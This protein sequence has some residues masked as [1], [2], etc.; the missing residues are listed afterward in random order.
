MSPALASVFVA[1]NFLMKALMP[2]GA[3]LLYV[4]ICSVVRGM[5]QKQRPDEGLG[6]AAVSDKR[7]AYLRLPCSFASEIFFMRSKA[8]TL[9]HPGNR[10]TF[11]GG[12]L[13]LPWPARAEYALVSFARETV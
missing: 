12:A 7:Q 11:A 4:M 10:E 9:G 5:G 6:P 13:Q 2:S 1:V 8:V 3:E